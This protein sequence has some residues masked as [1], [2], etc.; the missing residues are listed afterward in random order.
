VLKFQQEAVHIWNLL[1]L[2]NKSG[3]SFVPYVGAGAGYYS[4]ANVD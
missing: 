4:I 3:K 1:L 2:L